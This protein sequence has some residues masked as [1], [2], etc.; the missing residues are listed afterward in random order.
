MGHDPTQSG[1][2]LGWQLAEAGQQQRG[3]EERD[4]V[5]GEGGGEAGQPGQGAADR[6]PGDELQVEGEPQ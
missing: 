5:E 2:R 6:G 3:G 4:C 1:A